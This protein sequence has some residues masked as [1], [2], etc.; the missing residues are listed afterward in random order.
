MS[1]E[2]RLGPFECRGGVVREVDSIALRELIDSELE[3][4]R[5]FFSV[6]ALYLTV[7]PFL[8]QINRSSRAPI[9]QPDRDSASAWQLSHLE[10]WAEVDRDQAGVARRKSTQ[11]FGNLGFIFGATRRHLER[12]A[13][14]GTGIGASL[15]RFSPLRL[16]RYRTKFSTVRATCSDSITVMPAIR[17]MCRSARACMVWAAAQSQAGTIALSTGLARLFAASMR[18]AHPFAATERLVGSLRRHRLNTG[19]GPANSFP[20]SRTDRK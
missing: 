1:E 14:R 11:V 17:A 6:S 8:P 19:I 4:G 7:P 13:G 15:R 9:A 20:S 10:Q 16:R 5:E 12:T 18:G 2:L 3:N